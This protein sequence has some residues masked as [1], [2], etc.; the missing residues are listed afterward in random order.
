MLHDCL[1]QCSSSPVEPSL[2]SFTETSIKS[3][4]ELDS[5]HEIEDNLKIVIKTHKYVF[6][7]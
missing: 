7:M 1:L 4:R 3:S 5:S 2:F 6:Y